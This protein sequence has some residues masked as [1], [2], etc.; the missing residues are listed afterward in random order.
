MLISFAGRYKIK[1]LPYL[2]ST[3]IRTRISSSKDTQQERV[4]EI[5]RELKKLKSVS[6]GFWMPLKPEL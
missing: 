3:E 6:Y 5:N 2:S 1:E 4:N